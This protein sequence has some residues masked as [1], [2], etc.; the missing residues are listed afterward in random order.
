MRG[1]KSALIHISKAGKLDMNLILL[2]LLMTFFSEC[3]YAGC[4]LSQAA[5]LLGK[6]GVTCTVNATVIWL[7]LCSLSSEIMQTD[8]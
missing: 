7:N 6:R 4:F 2:H 8:A 3:M 1:K 5:L